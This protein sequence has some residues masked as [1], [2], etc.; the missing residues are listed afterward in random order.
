MKKFVNLY[1]LFLPLV[2]FAQ[3][4]NWEIVKLGDDIILADDLISISRESLGFKYQGFLQQTKIDQIISIS[5]RD[6]KYEKK[7]KKIGLIG[8]VSTYVVI[9]VTSGIKTNC[10]WLKFLSNACRVIIITSDSALLIKTGYIS[11]AVGGFSYF[12]AKMSG[13]GIR[14]TLVLKGNST[15]ERIAEINRF[16]VKHNPNKSLY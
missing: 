14:D 9:A 10:D 5:T 8:A 1:L 15:L 4:P 11:F 13:K 12:L 16:Y 6:K 7:A 2:A 3:Q